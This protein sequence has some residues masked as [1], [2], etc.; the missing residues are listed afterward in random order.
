MNV[1]VTGAS[2][3]IG[4]RLCREVSKQDNTSV[5]GISRSGKINIHDNM[6][7]ASGIETIG[8]DL[9]SFEDTHNAIQSISKKIDCIIHLA[10][11]TFSRQQPPP[12]AP[13]YFKANFVST[14]NLLECCRIFSIRAF[15]LSSS[16]AVYGLA[17]GQHTPQHLPVDEEHEAKPYELYDASKHQAEQLCKYFQDRFGISIAILRYSRVYGPGQDKGIIYQAISKSLKNLP[18]EVRGDISTDFVHVDDVVQATIAA[19]QSLVKNNGSASEKQ[20]F[21]IGSGNETTLYDLSSTIVRLTGSSSKIN[22]SKDPKGRFSLDISKARK[23]LHYQ[24]M[25]LEEGLIKSIQ[26]SRNSL[27]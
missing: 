20:I 19:A 1:L 11:L 26:Y 10:G 21:N 23:V 25:S 8:C 3:F 13:D 7:A 22:Y 4:S 24:P 27:K 12:G 15:A 14:L 18:I 17:A 16:I 2:G 6:P 5:I 9:V